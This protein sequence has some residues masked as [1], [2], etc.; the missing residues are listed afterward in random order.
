MLFSID[1][2]NVKL[3]FNSSFVFIYIFIY[4]CAYIY[5]LKKCI[6]YYMIDGDGNLNFTLK[7]WMETELKQQQKIFL[8]KIINKSN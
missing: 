4:S 3:L 6:H 8:E 5:Y 7:I 2:L 1:P